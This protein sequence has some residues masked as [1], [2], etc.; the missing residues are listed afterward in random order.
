MLQANDDIF[1]STIVGNN[2]AAGPVEATVNVGPVQLP[3][4][5]G[6]VSQYSRHKLA[7]LQEKYDELEQWRVL[8]QL[9]DVVVSPKYL[10][11]SFLIKKPSG[12][13]RLVTTFT[14]I[15]RYSKPQPS[16]IL[17]VDSTL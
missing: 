4:R 10:N 3:Q 6:H 15:G 13:F 7:E 14:D 17:A 16:L 11:P 5:K 8:R 9:K 2:G 12:G 1:N